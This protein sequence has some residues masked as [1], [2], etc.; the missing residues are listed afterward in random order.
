MVAPHTLAWEQRLAAALTDTPQTTTALSK[1]T[2]VP[3]SATARALDHLRLTRR[4]MR[5]P[6]SQV[7]GRAC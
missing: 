6:L 4:A 1:A 7:D 3:R 5:Q 2:A